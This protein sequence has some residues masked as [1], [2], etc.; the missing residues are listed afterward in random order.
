MGSSS[1]DRTLNDWIA[2][3]V[4]EA[5]RQRRVEL[6]F[7]QEQISR[8]TG[9]HRPVISRLERGEHVPTLE[10]VNLFARV[11]RTSPFRFL[12]CLDRIPKHFFGSLAD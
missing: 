6:G 1:S 7:N 3:N 8:A 5:I 9:I 10:T 4:G 2:V 12:E 11:L